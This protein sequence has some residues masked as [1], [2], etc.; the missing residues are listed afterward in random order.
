[1]TAQQPSARTS[2]SRRSA[3]GLFG[4]SPLAAGADTRPG[5]VGYGSDER[6]TG[7]Q[8]AYGHTGGLHIAVSGSSQPGGGTTALSVYADLDVVAVVLANY[9]LAEIGG[10][11]G[12]LAQQDRIITQHA[13]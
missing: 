7:G 3:L 1:M 8:R 12:F 5:W 4:A 2:L 13:S 9:T 10:I 11:A 6:I